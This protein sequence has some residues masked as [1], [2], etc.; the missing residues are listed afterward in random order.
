MKG[1]KS[2]PYVTGLFLTIVGG[3]GLACIEIE[4][5]LLFWIYAIV[6]SI[7]IALCLVGYEK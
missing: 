6:F 3:T 7:G 2:K 1:Q 5:D 4:S